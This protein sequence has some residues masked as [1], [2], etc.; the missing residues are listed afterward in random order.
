ME[1]NKKSPSENTHGQQPTSPDLPLNEPCAYVN[2]ILWLYFCRVTKRDPMPSEVWTEA[3]VVQY[4]DTV[5]R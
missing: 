4:L 1:T 2:P 5:S 3:D